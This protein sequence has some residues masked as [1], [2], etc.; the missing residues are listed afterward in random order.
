LAQADVRES[1]CEGVALEERRVNAKEGGGRGCSRAAE[2]LPCS[3]VPNGAWTMMSRLGKLLSNSVRRH[4]Q[5]ISPLPCASWLPHRAP[6]IL[7][8]IPGASLSRLAFID[9]VAAVRGRTFLDSPCHT[10]RTFRGGQLSA[11]PHTRVR[12]GRLHEHRAGFS[13]RNAPPRLYHGILF[14]AHPRL[15]HCSPT[16]ASQ[17]R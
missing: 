7:T 14:D 4:Y 17:R 8:S 12:E 6:Y 1:V 3:V 15:P 9:R 5:N 11:T 16:A 13:L 2:V 10:R